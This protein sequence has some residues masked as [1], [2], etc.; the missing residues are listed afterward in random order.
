MQTELE[1]GFFE[2]RRPRQDLYL[3]EERLVCDEFAVFF[4]TRPRQDLYV[5]LAC[6]TRG[7]KVTNY[8]STLKRRSSGWRVCPF[9]VLE[10]EAAAPIPPEALEAQEVPP[11]CTALQEIEI[12][13]KASTVWARNDIGKVE[14]GTPSNTGPW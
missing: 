3:P 7:N 11:L 10:E 13:P 4:E 12:S 8:R 2:T 14:N 9:P 5:P 6:W 1:A